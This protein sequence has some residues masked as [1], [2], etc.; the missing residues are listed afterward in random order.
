[1]TIPVSPS[2]FRRVR[3][4]WQGCGR[5][6][7]ASR[8]NR[9]LRRFSE[10]AEFI[11][12]VVKIVW[13]TEW[14][15]NGAPVARTLLTKFVSD[16]HPPAAMALWVV[17]VV[18]LFLVLQ[19]DVVVRKLRLLAVRKL[20]AG[21]GFVWWLTASIAYTTIN[22]QLTSILTGLLVILLLYAVARED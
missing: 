8:L 1:M 10:G 21:V 18:H 12:A 4:T 3:A 7:R 13:A 15:R 14:L 9:K 16:Y 17:G 6:W 22:F 20:C 2:R 19:D 11:S 5:R